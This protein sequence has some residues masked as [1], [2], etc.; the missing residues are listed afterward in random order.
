MDMSGEYRIPAPRERVW[1]A[2][3]DPEVLKACIPGCESL[4]GTPPDP[5][6]ATVAAAVG[7]VKARFK[8]KVTFTD[9]KPLE[10]YTLN[11]EG[12]GGPAGF[13]KG[14]A[15]VA[16]REEGPET[17]LTYTVKATIGGKLAQ[18]GARLID[19]VAKKNADEFFAAFAKAATPPAP[20]VAAPAPAAA[21]GPVEVLEPAPPGLAPAV[22]IGGLLLVTAIALVLITVL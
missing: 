4:T 11:G 9:V 1:Q 22:W 12:Q 17:V 13:A 6:E 19:G 16:L 14:S 3:N 7:P 8:G 10:G 5:L 2:L 18:I 20:V 21:Q 15:I